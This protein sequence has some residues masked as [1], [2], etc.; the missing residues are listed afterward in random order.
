M[1]ESSL[2]ELSLLDAAEGIRRR[3]FSSVEYAQSLL[4]HMDRIEPRVQAFV[5]GT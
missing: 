3:A 2:E 4:A 1:I 5:T